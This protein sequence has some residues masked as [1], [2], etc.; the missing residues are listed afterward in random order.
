[1]PESKIQN[2]NI[3]YFVSVFFLSRKARSDCIYE[4]SAIHVKFN[5]HDTG[6]NCTMHSAYQVQ[7][8]NIGL[9]DSLLFRVD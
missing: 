8:T 9:P 5:K 7:Y 1:M 4:I 3:L 2:Y 6:K